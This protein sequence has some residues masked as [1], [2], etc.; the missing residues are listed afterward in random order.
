MTSDEGAGILFHTVVLSVVLG[1]TT[2]FLCLLTCWR[3]N[4]IDANSKKTTNL[5]QL[6]TG[7]K[8]YEDVVTKIVV[9]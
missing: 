9:Q 6:M 4:G 8:A 2:P 7:K 3:C 5:P 1:V